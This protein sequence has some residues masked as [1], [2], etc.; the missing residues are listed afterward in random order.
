MIGANMYGL[1]D[2]TDLSF[3]KDK[4]LLQVCIGFNEVILNFD[5]NVS[6]TAQTDFAHTLNGEITA[7]YK[8]PIP[9][10]SMLVRFLHQ[11]VTR[12]SI[13]PPGTLILDFSNNEGLAIYDTSSEYESYQINHNGKIIVV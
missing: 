2:S 13:Q 7:V 9:S 8:A 11:S 4:S 10:A 6:I 12:V 5:G 3:I 1:P